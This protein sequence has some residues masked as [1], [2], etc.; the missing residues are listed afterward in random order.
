VS[1][2]KKV[3]NELSAM[4]TGIGRALELT[5]ETAHAAGQVAARAAGSGFTGIAQRMA[6]VRDAVQ[7]LHGHIAGIG[8]S[9]GEARAP[10]AQAPDQISPQDTI[11]VLD[12]VGQQ[13]DATQTASGAAIAKV[14][15]ICQLIA[16]ALQGGQPGPLLQRL[17]A[18]RQVLSAVLQRCEAAKQHVE[19][20]LA[21]AR[22][23]GTAGN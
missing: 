19:A 13:V 9:I 15:E 4:T 7:E 2:I 22:R 11:K 1:L 8:Q 5:A 23:V 18:I 10:V 16:A 17:D 12:P 20:A 3:D 14:G 6:G 21:E